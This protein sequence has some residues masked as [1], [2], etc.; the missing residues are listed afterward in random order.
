MPTV[1]LDSA[2]T[3]THHFNCPI[4]EDSY[5]VEKGESG[6]VKCECIK[7]KRL[8][9]REAEIP[10]YNKDGFLD[11]LEKRPC[12][13]WKRNDFF[14]HVREE[15]VFPDD[16]IALTGNLYIS[17]PLRCGKTAVAWERYKSMLNGNTTIY[18]NE[19]VALLDKLRQQAY[20][21]KS[22]F[23][24]KGSH[25]FIDELG[26]TTKYTEDRSANL[27]QLINDILKHK[28]GLTITSNLTTGEI[29]KK[30]KLGHN[31][32]RII[33]SNAKPYAIHHLAPAGLQKGKTLCGRKVGEGWSLDLATLHGQ[34]A[35]GKLKAFLGYGYGC[36]VCQNNLVKGL[37]RLGQK[38]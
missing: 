8:E 2:L 4:C 37:D 33:V 14:K 36:S 7:R 10:E 11:K 31:T 26:G 35:G 29:D 27:Y 6:V 30:S 5:W 20:D 23:D 24:V 21:G 19:E 38:L 28:A 16:V 15:G 34:K 1:S 22:H 17:G 18:F 12:T 13:I 32:E 25:S 3:R 9:K